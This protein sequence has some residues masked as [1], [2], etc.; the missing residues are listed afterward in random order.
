ME[1]Q[2]FL[3]ERTIYDGNLKKPMEF[4]TCWSEYP[5]DKSEDDGI[6]RLDSF[7]KQSYN[8]FH[9]FADKSVVYAQAILN[10]NRE[11][12]PPVNFI[13]R[14][15]RLNALLCWTGLRHIYIVYSD[16]CFAIRDVLN[17]EIMKVTIFN[18]GL[19]NEIKDKL[20]LNML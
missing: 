16:S 11:S 19:W 4:I 10:P 20:M 7:D 2:S 3:G 15:E 13:T 14:N 1:R 18:D 9:G 5:A 8:N 6:D 12:I 17:E